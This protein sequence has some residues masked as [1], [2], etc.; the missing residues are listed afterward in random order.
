[1]T[2][3]SDPYDDPYQV[4][5]REANRAREARWAR[6]RAEE[7]EATL[8][9]LNKT[10]ALCSLRGAARVLK[11]TFDEDGKPLT[12]FLRVDDF[13]LET[14]N[15]EITLADGKT[16]PAGEVWLRHPN[17]RA[18]RAVVFAPGCD[19]PGCYNLWKGFAVEA[20]GGGDYS[21]Y[22]KHLLQN[23]CGGDERLAAWLWAWLAAIVQHPDRPCGVAVVLRG[24]GLGKS[25]FGQLFGELLGPHHV[26]A[27]HPTHITGRF[28]SHLQQCLLLQIDDAILVG[29]D[30]LSRLKGLITSHSLM[31]ERKGIDAHQ[32]KNYMRLLIT[33]AQRWVVPAGINERRFAVFDVTDG[34]AE[35]PGMF[36][37]MREQMANGGREELLGE[38]LDADI[39]GVDLRQPPMTQG[40]RDQKVESLR[41]EQR[42]WHECL[43]RG[44]Q[45]RGGGWQQ[46]ISHDALYQDYAETCDLVGVRDQRAWQTGLGIALREL[47]PA[48][49]ESRPTLV[50]GR[51]QRGQP[52]KRR[53]RCY[54]FG[55]LANAR[56]AFEAVLGTQIDWPDDSG[57]APDAP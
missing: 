16:A 36:A 32:A 46:S 30:T 35:D 44:A 38:L 45:L 22:K 18:Y 48:L 6:E 56:A 21:L 25:L 33:S 40:L 7:L 17:R 57:G 14:A 2:R 43:Y 52:I 41:P 19:V 4:A 24:R 49:G 13:R 54:L 42:W 12:D 51:D 10:Y 5:R 34:T 31:V 26:T 47:Y 9:R 53:Q 3:S 1:M 28:N 8:N 20:G 50:A 15:Q 27:D 29:H 39:S 37:A 55:S 23:I 11:E